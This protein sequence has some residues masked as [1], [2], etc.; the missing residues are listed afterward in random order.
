[1]KLA[2][3]FAISAALHAV[4]LIYPAPF[5]PRIYEELIPVTVV[6]VDQPDGGP[7]RAG[8]AKNGE[9]LK[10]SM[11][12]G[13]KKN[14]PANFFR[15]GT[16]GVTKAEEHA[17]STGVQPAHET[18]QSIAAQIGEPLQQPALLENPAAFNDSSG[19][20]V[21]LASSLSPAGEGSVGS[22]LGNGESQGS[23][24]PGRYGAGSGTGSGGEFSQNKSRF[25]PAR[26]R[27][28]PKPLYP[29]SARQEGKEG[30][31]L[32]R[33]LV[34]RE[35]KSKSVEI[36]G[37]S[38]SETLDRAAVEAIRL[39]RFSPAHYGDKPVESWVRIPIDF[40]LT[41]KEN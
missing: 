6:G 26:Y 2:H 27:E 31:V 19:A 34:D 11:P 15:R 33:V 41:D 35:G 18:T 16:T 13:S 37:S 14:G 9:T 21:A 23:G 36:S 12:K 24:G 38:G 20:K 22:G 32:L 30:R 1:M 40:R 10:P 7:G 3:F 17:A 29:E 39:W 5:V 4:A 28:F 25:T 8:T